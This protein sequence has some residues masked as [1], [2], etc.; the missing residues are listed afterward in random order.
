M[1]MFVQNLQHYVETHLWIH[2]QLG[3][4]SEICPH[5]LG[6]F[7]AA[8]SCYNP[9]GGSIN[10]HTRSFENKQNKPKSKYNLPGGGNKQSWGFNYTAADAPCDELHSLHASRA[11]AAHLMPVNNNS[12]QQGASWITC[13]Q[14]AR[15]HFIEVVTPRHEFGETSRSCSSHVILLPSPRVRSALWDI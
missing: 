5:W 2:R 10:T 8:A 9:P 6:L 7:P 1:L 12:R 13:R 3:T 11:A 14:A 15:L 4:H